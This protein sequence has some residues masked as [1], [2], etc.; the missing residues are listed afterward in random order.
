MTLL[1]RTNNSGIYFPNNCQSYSDYNTF[2]VQSGAFHRTSDCHI[3][4]ETVTFSAIQNVFFLSYFHSINT[5]LENMQ[6]LQVIDVETCFDRELMLWQMFSVKLW[7]IRVD[8]MP[9]VLIHR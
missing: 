4:I 9:C 6:L 3:F 1:G 2:I 8:T 5:L 7:Q